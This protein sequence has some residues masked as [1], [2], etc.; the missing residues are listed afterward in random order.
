M[1]KMSIKNKI[2]SS[3]FLKHNL[4]FFIG[5][6]VISVFNYLYY[7]VLSRLVSVPEFGEIQAVIS[8]FMQLGIVLTA[9]GYVTTSIVAN[10]KSEK[11]SDDSSLLLRLEQVMVIIATLSIPLLFFSTLIF[12]DNFKFNSVAAMVLV[13]L[14]II[15][16]VPSTTRTYVLQGKRRL[17]EVSIGGSVFAIGKLLITVGLVYAITNNV[18]AAVLSYILAQLASLWYLRSRTKSDY[19]SVIQAF[20]IKGLFLDKSIR[21]QLI[22]Y[23]KYGLFI[24][25][26]LSGLA[27][28]YSSDTIVARLFF[29]E[30]EV[31]LYSGIASIARIIF[32]V[33][34]S[35]AGVLIASIR[36]GSTVENH[37][38]LIKSLVLITGIG[39]AG[40]I[41]FTLFKEFFVKL[42]VGVDYVERADLLPALSVTML[43]CSIAN[44]A[45]IYQIATR[46]Y[47]AVWPILAGVL[48]FAGGL[49]FY[50]TTVEEF[51]YTL[52][53]ANLLVVVLLLIQIFARRK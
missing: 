34:A 28:I 41:G 17:K 11:L 27:L 21:G 6:M 26:I 15:I 42:L 10:T 16:N 46:Y 30:Y 7:P 40:V 24:F 18:V 13:G 38:I 20:D 9:Y 44:L 33:T 45:A 36:I 25:F 3:D 2:T 37:K 49:V 23:G 8:L 22:H 43:F 1:R 35:I 5:T 19:A 50:V 31:G 4:V 32:F 52:M 14:L 29:D 12:G 53:S 47:R 39:L 51:V 48:G